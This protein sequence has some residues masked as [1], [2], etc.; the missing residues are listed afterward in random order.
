MTDI[1]IMDFC[2]IENPQATQLDVDAFRRL[3]Y[4]FDCEDSTSPL[5]AHVKIL[6]SMDSLSEDME[7]ASNDMEKKLI[8]LR[9]LSRLGDSK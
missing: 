6:A 5:E 8:L 9:R 1:E 7:H 4:V 3:M 2:R